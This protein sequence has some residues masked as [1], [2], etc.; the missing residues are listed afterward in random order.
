MRTDEHAEEEIRLV[1]NKI[2]DIL[3]HKYPVLFEDYELTTNGFDQN[4]E[5]ATRRRKA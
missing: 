5:W 1:F 2:G 3:K 4:Q